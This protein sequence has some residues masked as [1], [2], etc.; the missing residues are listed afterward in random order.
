M[1]MKCIQQPVMHAE[2]RSPEQ[3]TASTKVCPYC[4]ETIKEAA[5]VCRFCNREL[6][7][8]L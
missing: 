5:I 3:D 2:A 7:K 1:L 6:P 4:A 8:E